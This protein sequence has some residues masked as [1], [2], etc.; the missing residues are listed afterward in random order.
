M[1]GFSWLDAV[2]ILWLLWQLIYGLSAGLV[3][4]L[5]GLLGM[6]AGGAA[7]FFAAP[8]VSEHAPGPGWRTVFVIG[9]TVILIAIGHAGGI[10]IG[11]AIGKRVKS[12][13]VRTVNRLLG[14]ALNVLV[15]AVVISLLAFG[16]TNL[17]IPAVSRQLSSSVVI[18]K[19]DAWTPDPV[20]AVA[21]QMR[22]LVLEEGIPQL[23]NPGGPHNP[24]AAPNASTNTPAW[25]NAARSVLKISGT[26][27]QCGQNQTGSGF[28]VA[29]DRVLTN[30]HV[31]AGVP[32]PVVVTPSQ[33]S[34]PARVVYFDPVK[35]L[36]ILAVDGLNVAPLPTG[37]TLRDNSQAAFAGYPLGGPLQVR[38]ATVLAS[39]PMLIPDIEGKQKSVLD[40]YQL[41]GNVQSG[42][43]GGPLLDTS[44]RVVGVVFAKSTTSEPVGFAFTMAEVAPVIAAAP[45]LHSPV[46]SG[47]C[48]VK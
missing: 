28:V 47:Q 33:G 17:G 10:R 30:A 32:M 29:P 12:G 16:V 42:N 44:G 41:A 36:A 11:R 4:S 8:F 39:G 45:M 35:D 46:G 25:N 13:P 24:V 34:L 15:G 14:G 20:K 5:G 22:S 6:V 2:L 31:V 19:I 18:S 3:V 48:S 23:L 27:F 21:A 1:L 26:A 40:I 37:P 9:A 43:S 7:A 38:P